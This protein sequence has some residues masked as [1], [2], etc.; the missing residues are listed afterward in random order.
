M[1]INNVNLEKAG[2][3]VEEVKQDKNKALKVK[4]VEG[5]W[6]LESGKVQFTSTLEHPNGRT[7][8]EADG[9]PFMGGSGIKPDP[10]QYCLFGLAACYAQTFASIAAEKGIKLKHLKVA[11]ENKV[12]L[13]KA[14]GLSN[15]PIVEKVVLEI[16][17]SA[18]KGENLDEVKKLAEQRCPGVYCLTNAIKL[19]VK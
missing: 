6:N 11:A 17:A 19:E 5:T 15:E 14:L 8:V 4:R 9:P 2:A 10:V 1:K 12:N 3:F 16:N 7:I 18:S 13:S